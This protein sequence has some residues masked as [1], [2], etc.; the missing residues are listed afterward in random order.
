ME[1]YMNLGHLIHDE[2]YYTPPAIDICA[3]ILAS[4]PH[5][6][7]KTRLRKAYKRRDKEIADM[8]VN[9]T[10]MYAYIISKLSKE[11]LDEVQGSGQW[12]TIEASRDP[13]ELWKVVKSTHQILTTSKVASVIK[14]TVR[15]E[16]ATCKQGPFE[17]IVDY[18]RKFDDRLDALKVS[19]N[20][21][22]PDEDVAMDFMYGLGNSRYAEFKAEIVNDL[23]K[24]TLTLIKTWTKCISSQVGK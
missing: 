5:D 14:K 12:A 21:H 10:S 20:A 11:S 4:D 17:H 18:K 13:L 22:P 3:Y 16:Y 19:G 9:R 7:E 8:Q 23:T 15:E 24:G 2:D 1:K 6:V